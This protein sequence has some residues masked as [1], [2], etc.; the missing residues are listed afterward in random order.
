MRVGAILGLFALLVISGY[1]QQSA[2]SV[3]Q[4]VQQQ[5]AQQERDRQAIEQLHETD[6]RAS[7][8]LDVDALSSLWT[9]DIVQLPP[10][11]PPIVGR[12]ANLQYLEDIQ[13]ELDNYEI[14]GYNQ[15]WQQVYQVDDYA[16][17]W[18]FIEERLG[19][20]AGA[21]EIHR[22][23]KVM[24]I[25]KR[26]SDGAWKI[27]RAMWNSA[28]NAPEPGEN[29]PQLKERSSPEKQVQ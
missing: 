24:R 16:F 27:H 5:Q 22:K 15:E 12:A 1:A 29:A 4:R 8:A 20:P 21:P 26:G 10:G 7:M 14:L 19:A 23:Y 2:P 11:G 3:R 17:E 6:I 25:L 28:D 13:K 9:D 18:G